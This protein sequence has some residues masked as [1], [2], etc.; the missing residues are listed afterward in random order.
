MPGP[1]QFTFAFAPTLAGGR[2]NSPERVEPFRRYLE[3][4]LD[5]PVHLVMH[6]SYKD[7]L[8]ALRENQVDA[9]MMGDFASRV[10]ESGGG[11]EPLV[12]EVRADSTA[13][14]YRSAV[15]TRSDTGI[16][17]LAM[18]RG[19]T[20][21]LV[22]GQS[23]SGYLVPRAMLREAGLDPDVDLE[24]R[25]F[26]SHGEVVQALLDGSVD[27]IATHEAWL[28]PKSLDRG[29]DY[30]RLRV[31]V[32]SQ[33]IP[34]GPMV[35]RSNLDPD[36]RL[37][38][39]AALL[40]IHE[41]DP[42]AAR[43]LL[44]HGH[45]FTMAKPRSTPTLKS[46][47]SLAGVSYATVSRVVNG[48]GYVAPDTAKRVQA[49]VDEMGY[50]PNGNARVLMGRQFPIVGMIVSLEGKKGLVKHLPLIESLRVD[51]EAVGVPVV[52]C[53]AGKTLE[54]SPFVDLLRDKRLGALVVGETHAWDP[55]VVELARTG[56]PVFALAS[57]ELPPGIIGVNASTV[58]HS[59][60]AEFGVIWH[61]AT[62]P[63]LLD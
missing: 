14:T 61:N 15:A 49:I 34:S 47:A 22:D 17:S 4:S 52:L 25:L 55:V 16:R 63:E 28:T 37:R 11:V 5:L 20:L 9:A 3:R 59:I 42:E 10:G 35:V 45:H 39:S 24:I 7:T 26:A 50:A 6:G 8:E 60:G 12:S 57:G 58:A 62:P 51:L 33:P 36:T 48:V 38:L 27:A 31:L 21:G 1:T 43:V 56:H 32:R 13:R 23:T 44:W 2:F 29:P 46:I 54:T 30:A 40:R 41:A 53:P 19:R 18:L